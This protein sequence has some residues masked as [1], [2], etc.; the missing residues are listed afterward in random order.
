M[1]I[2]PA[3]FAVVIAVIVCL[4]A[5][6]AWGITNARR[7]DA[8][9]KRKLA[10][11]REERDAYQRRLKVVDERN[12]QLEEEVLESAR[13]YYDWTDQVPPVPRVAV[14]AFLQA[15]AE[16]KH[17]AVA[18][19]HEHVTVP[20]SVRAMSDEERAACARWLREQ[21]VAKGRSAESMGPTLSKASLSA[22]LSAST[23]LAAAA[24]AVDALAG[25]THEDDAKLVGWTAGVLA[26]IEALHLEVHEAW[27]LREERNKL[28][29]RLDGAE[30]EI[31]TLQRDGI[32][33]DLARSVDVRPKMG[34][35]PR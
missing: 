3:L 17:A 32:H 24:D 11:V 10:E 29:R 4:F 15:A 18:Y 7:Y 34:A 6:V 28:R 21:A 23:M 30:V 1:T 25:L 22:I 31:A 26:R 9:V 27:N 12:L 5:V 2:S 19:L 13:S 20:P 33:R 14:K 16:G 8:A 35:E